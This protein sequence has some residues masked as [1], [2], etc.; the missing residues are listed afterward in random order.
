MVDFFNLK[1]DV[2]KRKTSSSKRSNGRFLLCIDQADSLL[3]SDEVKF[4]KFLSQMTR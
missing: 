3:E 2:Q 4:E 1:F